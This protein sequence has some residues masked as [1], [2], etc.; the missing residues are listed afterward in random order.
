MSELTG[1]KTMDRQIVLFV[2]W[3]GC[4]YIGCKHLYKAHNITQFMKT[5]DP[6]MKVVYGERAGYVDMTKLDETFSKNMRKYRNRGYALFASVP[7]LI[8]II[9]HRTVMNDTVRLS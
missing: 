4:T 5:T 2:V 3:F 1:I 7:L 6:G 8:F 9:K